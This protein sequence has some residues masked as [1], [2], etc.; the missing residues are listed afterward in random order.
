MA[1]HRVQSRS[2]RHRGPAEAGNTRRSFPPSDAAINPA[3]PSAEGPLA[4][5]TRL[6]NRRF[7][8]LAVF[9]IRLRLFLENGV[10]R[11]GFS[12]PGDTS[13][14]S[15][16][17]SEPCDSTA[18]SPAGKVAHNHRRSHSSRGNQT[19]PAL[20][21]ARGASASAKA[22]TPAAHAVA[23]LGPNQSRTVISPGIEVQP[24]QYAARWPPQCTQPKGTRCQMKLCDVPE[25]PPGN[26]LVRALK[27]TLLKQGAGDGLRR[28][29][30][31]TLH[32]RWQR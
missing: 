9:P 24:S 13:G 25:R 7:S 10:E 28:T 14:R 22:L 16:A 26:L 18:I 23:S 2:R 31:V 15:P 21:T 5:K 27:V 3:R 32:G 19:P 20:G 12:V 17:A 11:F 30:E 6:N 4:A 29:F 8:K 1:R